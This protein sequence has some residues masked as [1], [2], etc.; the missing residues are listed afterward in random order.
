MRETSELDGRRSTISTQVPANTNTLF[1]GYP[2]N[3]EKEVSI[4]CLSSCSCQDRQPHLRQ[5]LRK[6][7]SDDIYLGKGLMYY[8]ILFMQRGERWD[9]ITRSSLLIHTLNIM[10]LLALKLLYHIVL[11]DSL[12]HYFHWFY[13]KTGCWRV[14]TFNIELDIMNPYTMLTK[15]HMHLYA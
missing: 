11:E 12:L 15:L 8:C 14:P 13:G 10:A 4:S 9:E 2:H 7:S 6:S 5:F 1:I 3:V